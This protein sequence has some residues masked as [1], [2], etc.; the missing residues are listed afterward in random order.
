MTGPF[1]I[2]IGRQLGS[3]GRSIG[4]L[5]AEKFGIAYYDKEILSLAAA[6][7][8]LGAKVFERGDE[9]KSF[10]RGLFGAITPMLT[11]GGDFYNNQISEDSLFH[12]QSGVIQKMAAQHSSVF[13][14]RASDYILRDH[15]RSCHIFIAANT[16]DRI[17]HIM[18]RRGID[19]KH[20][21]ELMREAD[22]QRAG[23]YNFYASGTWGSADTYNLC[24][25]SSIL[26][27][28]RSADYIAQF[29]IEKLQLADLY[30]DLATRLMGKR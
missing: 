20:A 17:A 23:Y 22:Q 14:G 11:T 10:L 25:N 6:E 24:I 21:K 30:P 1:V 13:I 8:G 7:S 18:E 26:G 16:E 15:P 27:Y 12:I 28:E 3:G 29:V 4:H 19:R 9:R 5:L 2:T